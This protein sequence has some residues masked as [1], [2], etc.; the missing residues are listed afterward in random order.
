MFTAKKGTELARS[1]V[2]SDED[3]GVLEEYTVW[4]KREPDSKRKNK[5]K[6]RKERQDG[7]SDAAK[8]EN[9]ERTRF[10]GGGAN[11]AAVFGGDFNA[12][13]A[14]NKGKKGSESKSSLITSGA[15]QTGVNVGFDIHYG[16]IGGSVLDQQG[17]YL[18]WQ[19]TLL[20]LTFGA[21]DNQESSLDHYRNNNPTKNPF[22]SMNPNGWFFGGGGGMP[23]GFGT[24]HGEAQ[25]WSPD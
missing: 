12:D 11:A 25:V 2:E 6:R 21:I 16:E 13:V 20:N 10:A 4:G 15:A 3:T 17:E 9:G 18:Y 5:P 14:W 24:G 8:S 23:F 19:I 22:S 1:A 7:N